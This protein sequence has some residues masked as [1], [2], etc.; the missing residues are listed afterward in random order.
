MDYVVVV[1]LIAAVVAGVIGFR[2]DVLQNEPVVLRI[3]NWGSALWVWSKA[4]IVGVGLGGF[5]QAAQSIPWPVGN[6]PVHAHSLPLEWLADLG[7]FGLASWILLTLG[8][9]GVVRRLW[10][11]RPE[12]AAALL[13]IPVHNLVDFSLY[14]TGVALP[15][16]VLM[17]WSLAL[18]REDEEVREP[19]SPALRWIGVLAATGAVGVAILS[20]SGTVLVEAARGGGAPFQTRQ[21][22]ASQAAFLAPWSG[23]AVECVGALA[24]ESGDPAMAREALFFL[25]NRRWQCPRSAAR[26]QLMG[27][28]AFLA[29]DEVTGLENLWRAKVVQPYDERRR[30]DFETASSKLENEL[31]DP[32]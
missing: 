27:R 6:H 4:P 26:A 29:G 1:A 25:E 18:T 30:R 24:L 11:I 9:V 21:D 23:D 28:L 22:W 17:G 12:M 32:R 31:N 20:L 15:W 2:P 16:A 19:V 8:F 10:R 3:D 5:G 13:V 7:L 14:T